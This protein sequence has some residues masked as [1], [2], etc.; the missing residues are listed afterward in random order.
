MKINKII[1]FPLL[2]LGY[3][4]SI[5]LL[6][7]A[8]TVFTVLFSDNFMPQIQRLKTSTWK[9]L[10][11][12][13]LRQKKTIN[14]KV[15]LKC[16]P[17]NFTKILVGERIKNCIQRKI[18]NPKLQFFFATKIERNISSFM[19][20][21]RKCGWMSGNFPFWN[22]FNKKLEKETRVSR[23]FLHLYCVF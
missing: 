4:S 20:R 10:Q 12:R 2:G 5:S 18:W 8:T 1:G 15:F 3:H 6:F 7:A 23:A 13:I 22:Y 17:R 16:W 14:P 19:V 11:W 21:G 9:N